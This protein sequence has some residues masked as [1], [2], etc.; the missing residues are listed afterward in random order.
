M[1]SHLTNFFYPTSI[2]IAGAS[3]KPKS[4][5][6]EILNSVVSYGYTGKVYPVNPKAEKILNQKCFKSILEI[7]NE[8]DLAIVVVPKN[9]VEESID[10]LL[11]KNVKSIILIT[12]G[13]KEIGNEGEEI[14]NRIFEKIKSGGARL[15]GPNCMGIINTQDEIKLNATFVAEKPEKGS[16]AFLSQSGSI[17]AAILNSLRST[18]IKF[19]HFISVGNKADVSENDLISFWE[20]DDNIKAICLYLESFSDGE[21]LILKFAGGEINKPVIVLKAGNSASGIKAASSHTGALGGNNKVVDSVLKQFGIIRTHTLDELFNT[22]KVIENFKPPKGNRIAVI[23]NGGG[24]GILTV[25]LFES[26]NLI[27]AEID[28]STKNQ[29]KEIIHPEGSAE[30]PVDLLPGAT[31]DIFKKVNEI[32]NV[33]ENVDAVISIFVEPVMIS[34]FEVIEAV[35]SI[36][37]R[38]PIFQVVLPLPEFWEKYKR[39]SSTKKLLF[40][41]TEEAV[42]TISNM[43][44]Y[45]AG[46]NRKEHLKPRNNSILSGP[47]RFLSVDEVSKLAEIYNIPLVESHLIDSRSLNKSE[48]KISFPLVL[49][50]ISE[51]LIHKSDINGVSVNIKNREKLFEA[52]M[53]ILCSFRENNIPL[54]K[55]LVQPYIKAKHELLIGGF[56][57]NNFGPMIMFGTGGKYVEAYDDTALKSAYISEEDIDE[58]IFST[59]IGKILNGIRGEKQ[60]DLTPI[61]QLIKSTAQM[62]LDNPNIGEFD[63]NPVIVTNSGEISIVDV[64]IKLI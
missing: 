11:K 6:Y 27:L 26:N 19:A 43:I 1:D 16:I 44:F 29:L 13:F 58:I 59:K 61:K 7:D 8:I 32:L 37:N 41:S 31:A 48:P 25:D 35:N 47:S 4:I 21:N 23:T 30:N 55:F 33:D 40:K 42:S 45:S 46:K 18:E 51:K 54:E 24:Y 12:A 3:S 20:K 5:G 38:K 49:K 39:E 2:C 10:A 62:M 52:E 34:A 28:D 14:E 57:D 50:G 17:G 60:V 15:V 36:R 56:R 9:F 63:F 22:A 64:R 53:K